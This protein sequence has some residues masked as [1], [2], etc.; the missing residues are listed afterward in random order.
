MFLT[1]SI[2]FEFQTETPGTEAKIRLFQWSAQPG[3]YGSGCKIFWCS[4]V[5]P[6][7]IVDDLGMRVGAG[8]Q[9]RAQQVPWDKA[10]SS[11]SGASRPFLAAHEIVSLWRQTSRTA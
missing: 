5:V 7:G 6:A 2:A 10:N 4:G 3:D 8:R 1:S 9:Q 11:A